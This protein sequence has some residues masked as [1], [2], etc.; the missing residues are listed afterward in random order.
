MNEETDSGQNRNDKARKRRLP[1]KATKSHLE[2]AALHYLERFSTSSQNLKYVLLRRVMRSAHYHDT[3]ADEGAVWVDD[4]ITRFLHAG[5]L[6]DKAYADGRIRS[7][8]ARGTS[9]RTIRMKL[10]AKGVDLDLINA[11]FD[12]IGDEK[13]EDIDLIAALRF[14]KRRRLGPYRGSQREECREKDMAALARAGFSYHIAR[15]I[16]ETEEP[17]TLYPDHEFS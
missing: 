14:A 12:A 16:I 8:H 4:I 15:Q 10:R 5:L 11:V 13:S 7:L 9:R 1:R 17:E 2:N 6:D 3:D